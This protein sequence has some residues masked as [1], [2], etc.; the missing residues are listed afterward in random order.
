MPSLKAQKSSAHFPETDQEFRKVM[1][2][3]AIDWPKVLT[4]GDEIHLP[5][6]VPT[7]IHSLAIGHG[8]VVPGSLSAHRP[9]RTA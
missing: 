6:T 8:A 9:T 3:Q 7:A 1:A 2:D 4:V 5:V